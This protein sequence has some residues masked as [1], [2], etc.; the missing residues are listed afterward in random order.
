MTASPISGTTADLNGPHPALCQPVTA[1]T[2]DELLVAAA[3]VLSGNPDL[4]QPDYVTVHSGTRHVGFQF[5]TVDARE[6]LAALAAWARRIGGPI[7]T[8]R[9]TQSSDGQK[10]VFCRVEW[11]ADGVAIN[12][13]TQVTP[14]EQETT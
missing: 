1:A 3:R 12:A 7:V 13:Y 9:V 14:E 8:S 11:T 10:V 6:D 2:M 5:S 4:P